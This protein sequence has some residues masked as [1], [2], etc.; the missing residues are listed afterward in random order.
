MRRNINGLEAINAIQ[1]I[2]PADAQCRRFTPQGN[3]C[4]GELGCSPSRVIEGKVLITCYKHWESELKPRDAHY[5]WYGPK[6]PTTLEIRGET[7]G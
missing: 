5:V 3:R 1:G 2:L 6:R 7:Y 4:E